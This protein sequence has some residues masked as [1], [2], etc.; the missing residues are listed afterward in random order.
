[1]RALSTL[2]NARI[3][4]AS[5]WWRVASEVQ[6]QYCEYILVVLCKRVGTRYSFYVLVTHN[7]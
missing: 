3:R 5:G 4:R 7:S 6:N 2:A 1:M